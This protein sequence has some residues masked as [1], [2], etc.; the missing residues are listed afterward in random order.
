MLSRSYVLR[1]KHRAAKHEDSK[2]A[3]ARQP[4]ARDADGAP[5]VVIEITQMASMLVTDCA[6]ADEVLHRYC[7]GNV[8]GCAALG[9]TTAGAHAAPCLAT[10]AAT[11]PSRNSRGFSIVFAMPLEHSDDCG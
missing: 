6:V 3:E 4:V 1:A 8:C 7:V 5:C 2:C 10:L 9:A 11:R